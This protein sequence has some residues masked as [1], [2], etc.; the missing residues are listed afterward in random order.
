MLFPAVKLIRAFFFLEMACNS[1]NSTHSFSIT[2]L[3]EADK[4]RELL[5]T[6]LDDPA[7]T[8]MYKELLKKKLFM[9]YNFCLFNSAFFPQ[10]GL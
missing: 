3:C 9:N 7:I 10:V 4:G 5:Q 8:R 1:C 6:Y 2:K